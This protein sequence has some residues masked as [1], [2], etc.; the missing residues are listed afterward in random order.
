MLNSSYS[1]IL[2]ALIVG[3]FGLLLLVAN[4]KRTVNRAIF[5]CSLHIAFWLLCLYITI[6]APE[7][8]AMGFGWMKMT[9]AVG[10]LITAHFWIVKECIAETI[11]AR[12]ARWYL[13]FLPW[14][15][16]PLTLAVIVFTEAFIP[17]HS[18]ATHRLYGWGYYAFVIGNLGL[19]IFLFIDVSKDIRKSEG[20]KRLA[21]QRGVARG[22]VCNRSDDRQLDDHWRGYPRSPLRPLSAC[23]GNSIL[24]R[25]CFCNYDFSSFRCPPDHDS[26]LGANPTRLAII[27]VAAVAIELGV[28]TYLPLPFDLLVTAA[29]SL[30]LASVINEKL[31]SYFRVYPQATAARLAAF[32]VSRR[33]NS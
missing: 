19:Y 24:R 4:P 10:I 9:C 31:N 18:T 22:R 33:R 13:S 26:G 11:D 30:W 20:G 8:S 12:S 32:E 27:T 25:H 7:G 29:V 3:V 21:L 23:C 14:L 15:T 17:A 16:V 2:P 5:S 6:S 28:S 1:F